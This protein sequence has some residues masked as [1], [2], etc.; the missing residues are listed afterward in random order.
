MSHCCWHW[1]KEIWWKKLKWLFPPFFSTGASGWTWTLASGC[2]DEGSTTQPLLPVAATYTRRMRKKIWNIFPA[3]FL[4]PSVCGQT[5]TLGP[6]MMRQMFCHSTSSMSHRHWYQE[7]EKDKRS[8]FHYFSLS[9]CQWSD[10]N[11][12]PL[13]VGTNVLPLYQFNESSRREKYGEKVK[14]TFLLKLVRCF[15]V[16]GNH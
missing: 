4:S 6:G 15:K 14:N 2:R 3:I 1:E 8:F 12:R 5:Q 9:R 13:E 11:P 16:M 7:R 10:S